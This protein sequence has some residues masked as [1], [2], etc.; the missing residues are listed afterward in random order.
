MK[1]K[2]QLNQTQLKLSLLPAFSFTPWTNR[3]FKDCKVI[4]VTELVFYG[5]GEQVRMM[6]E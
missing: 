5:V 1:T 3:A 2:A 6:E 4:P